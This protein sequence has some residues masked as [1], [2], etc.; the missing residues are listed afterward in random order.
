MRRLA[1]SPPPWTDDPVICTHRFTNA[2]RAADRVSQYLIRYV[3]YHAGSSHFLSI[4]HLGFCG[5]LSVGVRR[6]L[7]RAARLGGHAVAVLDGFAGMPRTARVAYEGVLYASSPDPFVFRLTGLSEV[8]GIIKP[9]AGSRKPEAGSRKPEAGSRKPEAGSRKPEAGSRKPEA[10]SRKPEAGSRKPEAGSRRCGPCPA[11]VRGPAW[12]A[13]AP[14]PS[15]AGDLSCG[16]VRNIHSCR[17]D[18]PAPGRA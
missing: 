10:G 12:R 18:A 15:G 2:Y 1:G 14:H 17:P 11:P 8:F 6:A 13:T 16:S 5:I 4:A 9:E 7:S 3:L